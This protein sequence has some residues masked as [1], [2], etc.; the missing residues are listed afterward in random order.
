MQLT[1]KHLRDQRARLGYSAE[2]V[3]KGAGISVNTLYAWENAKAVKPR[4]KQALIKLVDIL[5]FS[6]KNKLEFSLVEKPKRGVPKGF[7]SKKAAAEAASSAMKS[8]TVPP[9]AT[10]AVVIGV[11][12]GGG[13]GDKHGPADV[14][15]LTNM[16]GFFMGDQTRRS[17]LG[18]LLKAAVR[19][20]LTIHGLERA[21][22][23]NG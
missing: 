15:E 6:M 5:G 16:L 4:N 23:G 19:A 21:I 17:N 18:R 12:G 14:A 11:G 22:D 20:G 8:V 10:H 9:G 2:K 3:A 13:G 7:N 1:G